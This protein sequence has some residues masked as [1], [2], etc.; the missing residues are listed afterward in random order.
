MKLI[1]TVFL[2]I[3]KMK[4]SRFEK[5][6]LIYTCIIQDLEPHSKH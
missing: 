5:V 4:I 3:K 1:K 6:L 2:K